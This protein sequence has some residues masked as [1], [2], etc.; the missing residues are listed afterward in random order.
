MENKIEEAIEELK[1]GKIVL[2][3]DR[4][5]RENETDMMV[6]AE[7]INPEHISTLRE[8]AGG[9]ICA[10]IGQ[11]LAE[12]IK[13]PFMADV[14]NLVKENY[15]VLRYTIPD[16]IPYDEK[17]SFSISVNHRDT[18]TGITDNDRA[19]TVKK[20]AEYF[21]NDPRQKSF[22]EKFRSPGHIHLL[23]SSGLENRDGHTELTTA[24]LEMAGMTP[25]ACICEMM[26]SETHE[27]L[28]TE[29]V[30]KYAK[31]NELVFLNAGGIKEQFN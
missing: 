6:A 24:L 8:D 17:S 28:S 9:L 18:F 30:R 5:K 12:S 11:N 15:P 3:H 27:A 10:A 26:D 20:L 21:Q 16:D 19:L 23:R 31:E 1:Q 25:V 2:V 7:K 29:K 14:L 22:G 4:K 13:L